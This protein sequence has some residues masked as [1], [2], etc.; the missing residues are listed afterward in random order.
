MYI[1]CIC[2]PDRYT[3]DIHGKSR[4][5]HVYPTEWI[6]VVYTWIYHVYPSCIYVYMDIPRIS[7]MYIRSISM[8]I[9]GISFDVYPWYIRGISMDIPRFL[10]PN[11][12]AC[13]CRCSLAMRTRLWVLKSVNFTAH[14]IFLPASSA[15]PFDA[16][17]AAVWVIKRVYSTRHH[18]N[19]AKGKGEPQKA[20]LR[21]T[22][23]FHDSVSTPRRPAPACSSGR[24]RQP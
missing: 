7:I 22:L 14:C 4:I 2:R 9:H 8:D 1:P 24:R 19:S 17:Q 21:V 3:W 10:N 11:F 12:P 18:G 13:P 15:L 23:F 6:Y 20:H 16:P 5:F